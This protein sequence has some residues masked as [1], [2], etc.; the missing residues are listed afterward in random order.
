LSGRCRNAHYPPRFQM[1][2][3]SM[4]DAM[5]RGPYLSATLLLQRVGTWQ[6]RRA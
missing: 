1:I 6:A 4:R 2:L 5:S 3:F